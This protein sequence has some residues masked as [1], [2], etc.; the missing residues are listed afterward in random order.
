MANIFKTLCILVLFSAGLYAQTA[1]S[2]YTT[3]FS[4]RKW[5]SGA[6][7][8]ADSLNANWADI[9]RAIRYPY[10]PDSTGDINPLIFLRY[11]DTTKSYIYRE[12]TG[13]RFTSGLRVRGL[14]RYENDITAF[15][16][17]LSKGADS[18]YAQVYVTA[19]G[20]A[21]ISGRRAPNGSAFAG[22]FTAYYDSIMMY[23][24][25]TQRYKLDASG[26]NAWTGSG[27]F[28]NDFLTEGAIS[29][30]ALDV[31]ASNSS[32][33]ASSSA[34]LI[35]AVAGTSS[36]DPQLL[37]AVTGTR[38]YSLYID[39]DD[40]DN[41][42][43]NTNGGSALFTMTTAGAVTFAG[44][45]A[46][47]GDDIT[48]DGDL[49]ITPAGGDVKV[50]GRFTA[51]DTIRAGDYT[52]YTYFIPGGALVQS[53]TQDIKTNIRNYSADLTK[54]SLVKPKKY[55]FKREAFIR[56]FDESTLPDSLSEREKGDIR[57]KFRADNLKEAE[58][59]SKREMVG[60]LA[61]E[62][63]SIL[64]KDSKEINQQD[65]INVLWLKIQ[66]L[67]QRIKKLEAK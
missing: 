50:T 7:P 53:S 64:G 19:A 26:N 58:E 56:L 31:K 21:G 35:S 15:M 67:E 61:E 11:N 22:F 14:G 44:D 43:I 12:V 5:A 30:G 47:N 8:S 62:F 32:N 18:T 42:E 46:V 33:T 57:Q 51:S 48:S 65:V 54:F 36:G 17:A 27:T 4:F 66:E 25:G 49:T 10:W 60:F 23:I 52:T 13:D 29:G 3:N 45:I 20:S 38:D 55:N 1:P 39:N 34:R 28:G 37:L 2:G 63:N 41:L 40:S 9:D 24:A 16:G 6:N 59:K